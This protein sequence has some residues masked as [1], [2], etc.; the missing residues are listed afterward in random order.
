MEKDKTKKKE[1]G[2]LKLRMFFFFSGRVGVKEAGV[3]SFFFYYYYYYSLSF[4][5]LFIFL[6]FQSTTSLTVIAVTTNLL[7]ILTGKLA[8]VMKEHEKDIYIS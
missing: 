4:F 1:I 3:V 7:T 8:I 6:E 5:S 2:W